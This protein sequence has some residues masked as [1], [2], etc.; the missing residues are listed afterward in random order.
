MT[1][2]G[3]NERT[4]DKMNLTL[5]YKMIKEEKEYLSRAKEMQVQFPDIVNPQALENI[6]NYIK[7]L[8]KAYKELGGKRK[9]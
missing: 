1:G 5:L 3:R 4:G 7:R 6:E 2:N 8:T 9:V